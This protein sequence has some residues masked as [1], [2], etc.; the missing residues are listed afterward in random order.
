[1]TNELAGMSF[2]VGSDIVGYKSWYVPLCDHPDE[3]TH[4]EDFIDDPYSVVDWSTVR[5]NMFL[6]LLRLLYSTISGIIGCL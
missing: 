1:M 2:A 3:L 5:F 4:P 6:E